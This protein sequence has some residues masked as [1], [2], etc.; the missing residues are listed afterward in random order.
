MNDRLK[1]WEDIKTFDDI[2]LSR[3]RDI[4]SGL[5]QRLGQKCPHLQKKGKFFYYCGYGLES[6]EPLRPSP[7]NVVYQK[8]QG[9]AELQLFC[10]G[11]FDKC[12]SYSK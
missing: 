12:D 10:M 4:I 1:T 7:F 9:V 6:I 8:H 5:E 2:V 11:C 3:E